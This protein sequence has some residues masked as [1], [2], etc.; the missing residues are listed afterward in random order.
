MKRLTSYLLLILIPISGLAEGVEKRESLHQFKGKNQPYF[1]NSLGMI[2]KNVSGVDPMVSI[3]ETRVCDFE[4]FINE[5]GYVVGSMKSFHIKEDKGKGWYVSL[6]ENGETWNKTEFPQNGKHPVTGVNKTDA[7][8]FA[9]WLTEKDAREGVI[10]EGE[11]YRLPR[12][13][14]FDVLVGIKPLGKGESVLKRAV[15][16]QQKYK[17]NNWRGAVK[18]GDLS[19]HWG[20]YWPATSLDGNFH[21]QESYKAKL[22]EL[23]N[24]AYTGVYANFRSDGYAF[25]APVGTYSEDRNGLYDIAGNV[26][27]IIEESGESDDVKTKYFIRGTAWNSNWDWEFFPSNGDM[28]PNNE[29]HSNIGFR[30]VLDTKK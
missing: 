30:L 21:S 27:E 13:C 15:G 5:T 3:Y 25:T 26:Y 28:R 20:N 18:A 12:N 23:P 4:R 11:G 29:R 2:F 7:L 24:D 9:K 17:D 1:T 19:F 22:V 6:D 14:E 16:E 10:K 8:A